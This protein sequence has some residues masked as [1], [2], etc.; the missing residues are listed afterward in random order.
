M[1]PQL[2]R[3]YETVI[4]T[5]TD[6]GQEALRKFHQRVTE[7]MAK[8]GAVPVR[9]EFWGK[10]KLAYPIKKQ[11]KAYYMFHV[12]LAE[13]G[14][15]D[16]LLSMLKLS[17]VVLRYLVVKLDEGIDPGRYDLERERF[18]DTLPTDLDEG[19]EHYGPIT[20]WEKEFGSRESQ[21][22]EEEPLEE[23]AEESEDYEE[24]DEE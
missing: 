14:F 15:V 5:R 6:A 10:R 23:G 21:R 4:V 18:F 24:P 8:E 17:D 20:G 11:T 19:K 3:K 2:L 16:K 1:D 22:D 13:S 12:Y 9:F 7:L